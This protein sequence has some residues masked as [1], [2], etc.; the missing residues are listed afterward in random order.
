MTLFSDGPVLL[1]AP[2][3]RLVANSSG[4]QVSLSCNFA[5][6]PKPEVFWTK[7]GS[8]KVLAKG[9]K[10]EFKSVQHGDAGKYNCVAQSILGEAKGK[11]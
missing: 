7:T 2:D 9:E 8:D 11:F 5:G 4:E 1:S 10:M 3:R 6:N